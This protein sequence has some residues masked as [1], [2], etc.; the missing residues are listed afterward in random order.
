MLFKVNRSLNNSEELKK[1]F[2]R[3]SFLNGSLNLD[4]IKELGIMV[5]NA[6]TEIENIRE[7][8]HPDE[9]M[10]IKNLVQY[11]NDET[12]LMTIASENKDVSAP[13]LEAGGEQFVLFN[14]IVIRFL[15][16]KVMEQVQEEKEED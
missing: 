16:L 12:N 10:A 14:N 11:L 15:E 7:D 1:I 13:A 6:S 9:K 4:D 8:L 2:S 5:R 3:D